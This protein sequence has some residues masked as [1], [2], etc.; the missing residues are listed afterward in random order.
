M[1]R[2]LLTHVPNCIQIMTLQDTLGGK[3][4]M[5]LIICC[6]PAASDAAETLSSLRFGA[7]AKGIITSIQVP[8]AMLLP[9]WQACSAGLGALLPVLQPGSHADEQHLVLH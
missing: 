6:S 5:A 7:R 2:T 1:R 9:S 4:R 8:E 3:A